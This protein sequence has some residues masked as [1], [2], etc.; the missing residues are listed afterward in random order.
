MLEEEDAFVAHAMWPVDEPDDRPGIAPF[1]HADR[2]LRHLV[3]W[4]RYS[5]TNVGGPKRWTRTGYFGHTPVQTF[6]HRV[7]GGRNVPLRGPRIVLLDTAA[8]LTSNGRLS[9][10]CV[11]TGELVQTDRLGGIVTE[12]E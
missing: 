8:A 3:L 12:R 5:E 1:L 9:A 10:V 4:G 2:R 6:G 11:E 7:N